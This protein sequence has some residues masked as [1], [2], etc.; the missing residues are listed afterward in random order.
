MQRQGS[1]VV[2]GAGNAAF[3]AALSARESGAQVLMLEKAAPEEAHGNT[4]FTAG[5]MRF[6][7]EDVGE[8]RALIPEL[9][10][11]ELA[12]TDFGSYPAE[13]YRHDIRRLNQRRSDAELV[14]LLVANSFATLL[15]MREQGVRFVPQ[16]ASQSIRKNG[17][18]TFFGGSTL[19]VAGGGPG[20]VDAWRR[21]AARQGV[22]IRYPSCAE[23]LLHDG[24]GVHGVRV[25]DAQGKTLEIA[26]A[27][28]SWRRGASRRTPSGGPP[29][30][31]R[32]ERAKVR[33]T[34]HN[35][36][37]GIRMALEA[38]P[39]PM[40]RGPAATPSVGIAMP[41]IRRS[42]RRQPLPEAQL[43]LRHQSQRPRRAL[44]R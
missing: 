34:R 41:R 38:A 40:D 42:V 28:S 24:A 2:I 4:R 35:T 13:R 30:R 31:L 6:A 7:Y 44:R 33:G 27:P 17:K 11:N 3:S 9:T 23:G 21:A 12:G 8:L 20:L 18:V 22:Q 14:D 1:V 29:P 25:R 16:Y 36:G 37:D 26:A 10:E 39:R 43:S 32:R 5:S 15:W 19:E